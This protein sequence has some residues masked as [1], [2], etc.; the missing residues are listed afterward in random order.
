MGTPAEPRSRSARPIQEVQAATSGAG[1]ESERNLKN[2]RR[3]PAGG[4]GRQRA[5]LPAQVGWAPATLRPAGPRG[6][7]ALP[8]RPADPGPRD[9][10]TADPGRAAGSLPVGGD[11][12]VS[13]RFLWVRSG[14]ECRELP[15]VGREPRLPSYFGRRP[16]PRGGIPGPPLSRLPPALS[17]RQLGPSWCLWGGGSPRPR[18]Q[19][20]EPAAACT[21]GGWVGRAGRGSLT[22][23]GRVERDGGIPLATEEGEAV[24][25]QKVSFHVSELAQV[26]PSAHR[27]RKW[28]GR[29]P[30][31]EPGVDGD[32]PASL[33]PG[34]GWEQKVPPPAL[35][36]P[37]KAA[38][39][40]Q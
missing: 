39:G 17:G 19:G 32:L 36:P 9:G 2:A 29:K 28:P 5:P 7:P 34:N 3:R 37:R 1:A 31:L 12:E 30:G 20:G 23:W 18:P 38:R 35:T 4:R 15:S 6:P 24:T 22:A 8:P 33:A 10:S 11:G 13:P 21:A 16:A 26:E 27:L 40:T 14:R 25:L